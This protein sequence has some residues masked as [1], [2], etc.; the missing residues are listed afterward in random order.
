M[1]NIYFIM[2]KEENINQE[3]I[4]AFFP[5][6]FPLKSTDRLGFVFLEFLTDHVCCE[7][8]RNHCLVGE[9]EAG[10]KLLGVLEHSQCHS[11]PPPPLGGTL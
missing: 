11:P 1:P 10:Q 6:N 9:A 4:W 5:S 2:L 8:S 3:K 7:G